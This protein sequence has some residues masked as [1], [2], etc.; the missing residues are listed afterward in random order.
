MTALF[1]LL[2][3]TA[4]WGDV[5]KKAECDKKNDSAYSSILQQCIKCGLSYNDIPLRF[6]DEDKA[7]KTEKELDASDPLDG[8]PP[9]TWED[10]SVSPDLKCPNPLDL[11]NPLSKKYEGDGGKA[12]LRYCAAFLQAKMAACEKKFEPDKQAHSAAIKKIE[13][14]REKQLKDFYGPITLEEDEWDAVKN[15][16]AEK[17]D[18]LAVIDEDC[19][20]VGPSGDAAAATGPC[21][22]PFQKL[23][24]DT[25]EK[26]KGTQIATAVKKALDEASVEYGTTDPIAYI[27]SPHTLGSFISKNIQKRFP[28]Y[29]LDDAACSELDGYPLAVEAKQ[30]KE[31]VDEAQAVITYLER[32]QA[33]IAQK[34]FYVSSELSD[35]QDFLSMTDNTTEGS[36][37]IIKNK[38]EA[39]DDN[40]LLDKIIK[41]I[42]QILGT[43]GIIMLLVGAIYMIVSQG[44]EN[45]LQKG[46]Q[47]LIYTMLG[48]LLGFMSYTVVQLVL[49]FIIR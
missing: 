31:A 27:S 16:A 24:K 18:W 41:L 5:V 3:P 29:C 20:Y 46:K 10:A 22:Q 7:G 25:F 40:N 26:L 13:N 1:V 35:V 38:G 4:V 19:K 42:S 8:A 6:K 12:A 32:R 23:P 17:N 36:L 9:L 14:E 21:T 43:F 39:Q 47:I 2:A 44:D 49:D 45:Q 11:D 34:R 48:L 30:K 28:T 37:R 15:I 33:Q